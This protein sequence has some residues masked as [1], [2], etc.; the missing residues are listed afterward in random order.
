[1]PVPERLRP[2][3]ETSSR[4][5]YRE[6]PLALAGAS[7]F[8]VLV[9]DY[10]NRGTY[11]GKVF[12]YLAVNRP[13]LAL[14]D[15]PDVCAALVNEANAGYVADYHDPEAIGQALDR[16]YQ[17]WKIGTLPERDWS[18]V[19]SSHRRHQVDRLSSRLIDRIRTAAIFSAALPSP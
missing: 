14:V 3:V 5:P 17:D 8:L 9:D 12:D 1:M 2:Y 7:A 18:V 19:E 15:P 11:T 16:L 13:I 4:V 10:A 6:L